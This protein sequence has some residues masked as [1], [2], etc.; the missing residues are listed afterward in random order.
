MLHINSTTCPPFAALTIRKE[1]S[2]DVGRIHRFAHRIHGFLELSRDI[3]QAI[4][5]LG[6]ILSKGRMLWQWS[7]LQTGILPALAQV[8]HPST[9]NLGQTDKISLL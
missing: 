7:R 4:V 6:L 8:A 2:Q 5:W 1:P 9:R 3:L